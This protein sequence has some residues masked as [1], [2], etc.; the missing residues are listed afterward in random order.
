MKTNFN[1]VLL[2]ASAVASLSFVSSHVN[3]ETL[4]PSLEKDLTRI[5]QALK[6]DSKLALHRAVKRSR[7]SYR[8]ID[9][10]LVCN[11]LSAR[12]FALTHNAENTANMLASRA[13]T[14]S[15]M[16]AAHRLGE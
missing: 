8:Q 5:C 12:D 13:A 16:L 15:G 11:G 1:K 4:S 14:N 3:A 10:G 7:L 2:I 9:D 6:S